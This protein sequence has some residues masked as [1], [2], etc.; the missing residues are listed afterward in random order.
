[1][2]ATVLLAKHP[3]AA[4]LPPFA[5]ACQTAASSHALHPGSKCAVRPVTVHDDLQQLCQHGICSKCK[6][7]PVKLAAAAKPAIVSAILA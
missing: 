4:H 6:L 5:A 2:C 3:V 1:M 7:S